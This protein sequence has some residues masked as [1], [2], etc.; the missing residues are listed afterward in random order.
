MKNREMKKGRSQ[1]VVPGAAWVPPLGTGRAQ[2]KH[3]ASPQ[4]AYKIILTPISHL[5]RYRKAFCVSSKVYCNQQL[6]IPIQVCEQHNKAEKT[7]CQ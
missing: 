5:L 2:K 1:W 4:N 7:Y 6:S 3:P